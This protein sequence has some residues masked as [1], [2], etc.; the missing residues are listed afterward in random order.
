MPG[1]CR[2][3]RVNPF[4]MRTGKFSVMIGALLYVFGSRE[5]HSN[6]TEEMHI[7]LRPLPRKTVFVVDVSIRWAIDRNWQAPPPPPT[8]PPPASSPPKPS[9]H[10]AT[11]HKEKKRKEKKRRRR[12]KKEA[13]QRSK[14]LFCLKNI[15]FA[16]K[17]FICEQVLQIYNSKQR[18]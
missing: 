5:R 15:F 13:P 4:L 6:L 11:H 14:R 18:G 16:W 3:V 2:T 12:R 1:N 17:F 8:P 7:P 9:T 10:P